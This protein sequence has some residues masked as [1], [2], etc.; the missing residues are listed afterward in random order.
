MISEKKRGLIVIGAGGH[1]RAVADAAESSG[2][3]EEIVFLDDRYPELV[4]PESWPI[5]GKIAD[6][7][8]ML[9]SF[10]DAVVGIGNNITRLAVL[11]NLAT[12]GFHLPVIAHPAAA[13]S[14]HASIGMGTVVLAQATV[15]VAAKV[16]M[17][18]IVNTA[19]VVEHDCVLGAGVHLSPGAGLA[20]GAVVGEGSWIGMNASVKNHIVIGRHVVVG[21]GAAVINDLPDGVMAVGVPARVVEKIK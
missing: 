19:V 4:I 6:A 3:W 11:K 15:N 16:G 10:P 18:C 14:R 12:L 5:V 20:G 17:G 2:Q 9:Q 1:G 7:G 8:T 21:L 13:I